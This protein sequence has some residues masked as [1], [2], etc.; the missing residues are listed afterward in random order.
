MRKKRFLCMVVLACGLWLAVSAQNPGY[1]WYMNT[2]TGV[3]VAMDEVDYLLRSDGSAEFSIVVKQGNPVVGVHRVTFDKKQATGIETEAVEQVRLYPNPVQEML[4][5]SG[6][7]AGSV[8]EIVALD[9][10]VVKRVE[11]SGSDLSIPVAD[12]SSGSYLLRT[13]NTTLK[14]IKR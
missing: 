13:A 9:G 5:M 2:D 12:L 3:S 14:F 4:R 8:V 7:S 1:R 11:A 6:L 10:R